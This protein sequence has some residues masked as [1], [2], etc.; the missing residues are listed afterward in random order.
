MKAI[1]SASSAS[2]STFNPAFSSTPTDSSSTTI[3]QYLRSKNLADWQQIIDR[4][5]IEWGRNPQSLRDDELEPPTI[6]ALT[7]AHDAVGKLSEL[8]LLCPTR[9]AVDGVGGIAF[10]WESEE[11]DEFRSLRF[12]ATGQMVVSSYKHGI[13]VSKHSIIDGNR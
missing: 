6:A 8:R 12:F 10:E 13:L 11:A 3:G 4:Q 2:S 5:L 9:A 7:K 1:D